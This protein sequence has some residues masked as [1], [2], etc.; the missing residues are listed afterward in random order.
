MIRSRAVPGDEQDTWTLTPT[1]DT[2]PGAGAD[3]TPGAGE[4]IGR[5]RIVELLGQGGM[6]VVYVARDPELDREVA[7]K[8]VHRDR[9]PGNQA[10]LV[11]EAQAMAKLSHANVVAVHDVGVVDGRVFIAME[12]VAGTTLRAHLEGARPPWRRV[13]AMFVA[14][15]RGLAAAHAAGVVHRDFKPDNVLVGDDG[16]V[17]V[18]DFG[19]ARSFEAG[20]DLAR[21]PG[22]APDAALVRTETAA[23]V[24]TPAYMAPEQHELEPVTAASDQYAFCVALWEAVVGVRP[25]AGATALALGEAKR[26]MKLAPPSRRA[27]GWLLAVLRRGLAV[28][29]AARFPSMTAL[30]EQLERGLGRGRRVAIAAAATA[31]VAAGSAIALA[32]SSGPAPC[33]DG[34]A[35]WASVWD[36]G[37]AGE[38]RAA[39]GAEPR[40]AAAAER[41]AGALDRYVVDWRAARLAVCRASR[42]GE[43]PAADTAARTR[44]LDRARS[45]AGGLVA[46]LID[47]PTAGLVDDAPALIDG[48]PSVADCALVAADA[49]PPMDAV[50]AGVVQLAE[51]QR[52]AGRYGEALAT[53]RRAREAAAAG[54][55]PRL[56]AEA[57]LVIGLTLADTDD[58]GA[59]AA[60]RRAEGESRA[61]EDWASAAEA[62]IALVNVEVARGTGDVGPLFAE[63][64]AVMPRVAEPRLRNQLM[65]AQAYAMVGAGKLAD[66]AELCRGAAEET[67][68][69][70]GAR[71]YRVALALAQCADAEL[72]RGDNQAALERFTRAHEIIAGELGGD[73]PATANLRHSLGI[74]HRRLGHGQEALRHYEAALAVRERVY[75][76]TSAFVADS[77]NSVAAARFDSGD[78][79]GAREAAD[80]YLVA[81]EGAFGP[82]SRRAAAAHMVV[83]QY[84]HETGAKDEVRT[85]VDRAFA[86]LAADPIDGPDVE[87]AWAQLQWSELALALGDPAAAVESAAKA[88]ATFTAV[89]DPTAVYADLLAGKAELARK[90]PADAIAPLERAVAG[91]DPDQHAPSEVA[92]AEF[93]LAQALHRANRDRPRAKALAT[94][95]RTRLIEAGDDTSPLRAQLDAWLRSPR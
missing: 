32:A 10:R 52:K 68:R 72:A 37:R 81:A 77:L 64:R 62:L 41:A 76:P 38:L 82:T 33:G 4:T 48:L 70:F 80:R 16:A 1:P 7:I 40:A 85:H 45:A 69:L 42:A 24:G 93:A 44:C 31:L 17:R 8:L 74:A 50:L 47:H 91:L 54:G 71:S 2:R 3:G 61:L 73:H 66:A 19:L 11:R 67:E 94:S 78:A 23:L 5:Y 87:L 55:D 15:G 18:A 53:A 65:L 86:L 60:L 43:T 56:V 63:V 27:P 28:D 49:G 29:P 36:G 89:D 90:R 12:L 25:F 83:A 30:I 46:V 39:F 92:G 75:G 9:A 34:A 13:V 51:A 26:Q 20:D 14:A 21:D 95:A 88:G 6:G 35:T 22:A 79:T 57:D 58:V 59:A 84:A